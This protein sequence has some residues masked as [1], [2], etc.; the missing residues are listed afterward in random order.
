M[1]IDICLVA[2]RRPD[3]LRRTL[4]SFSEK[5]LDHFE[6]GNFYANI[7]PAFGDENE[8]R[9]CKEI[10][11]KRFP[12]ASIN[13]PSSPSFGKAVQLT[14][15]QTTS[16]AF[17]HLEDDWIAN[18]EIEPTTIER[19]F[20]EREVAQ[21]SLNNVHKHWNF[22]KKGSYHTG[23]KSI[24][25]FGLNIRHGERFPCFTT[26]PSFVRGDFGRNASRLI[27]PELDPEKQFY[28][29]TNLALQRYA[30]NYRNYILQ[31][32]PEF[33]ITDI[34]RDWRDQRGISK[35][36]EDGKSVWKNTN[37]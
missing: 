6:V 19:V 20:Q 2:T 4:S 22:K 1:K 17:L 34:G 29:D 32:G 15:S 5:I 23:R 25:I 33:M 16:D 30:A 10:I 24:K 26:S 11:R 27:I 21:I 35:L 31:M 28:N 3:L 14:W 37:H 13:T 36:I 18:T 9:L 7:D 8:L 12:H